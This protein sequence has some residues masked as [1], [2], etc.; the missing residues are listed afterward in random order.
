[1]T[2]QERFMVLLEPVYKKLERFALS[3]SNSGDEA[4]EIV[5]ETLLAAFQSF[6]SIKDEKAFLSF[7]FT[8]AKRQKVKIYRKYSREV[9]SEPESFEY[10]ISHETNPDDALDIIHIHEAM[11]KLNENEREALSMSEFLGFSHKEIAKIQNTTVM[12]IKVRVFRA[13]KKLVKLLKVDIDI[14]E[15]SFLRMQE[16]VK[17]MPN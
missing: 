2:K 3:I 5:Q 12:N 7:I 11:N 14:K 8:I 6:G 13:K 9:A 4:K 10:L 17:D 16:S 15:V 1:L